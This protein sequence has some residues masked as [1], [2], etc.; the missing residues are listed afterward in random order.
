MNYHLN[1]PSRTKIIMLSTQYTVHDKT[2]VQAM[3]QSNPDTEKT[4]FTEEFKNL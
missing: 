4:N 2:C 3:L 1:N